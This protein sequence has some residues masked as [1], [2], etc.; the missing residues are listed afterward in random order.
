MPCLAL[1]GMDVTKCI[2]QLREETRG[3]L[4]SG[5]NVT[6]GHCKADVTL[7]N[8]VVCMQGI[9][10]L[11]AM[12]ILELEADIGRQPWGS[13]AHLHRSAAAMRCTFALLME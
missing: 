11:M 9:A 2:E 4:V 13:A 5:A 10:A 12:S 6:S 3:G 8:V 7:R 1:C